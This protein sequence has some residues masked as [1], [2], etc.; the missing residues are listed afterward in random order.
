[1]IS[2]IIETNNNAEDLARTLSSLVPAAVEGVV[3]D[4]T[5]RDHGSSDAT[6]QVCDEA[7][8]RWLEVGDIGHAIKQARCDW[9]LLLM[10]GAR[11]LDGWIEPA[12]LHVQKSA[13]P[14]R[15]ARSRAHR[16]GFL[17]RIGRTQNALA[18]GLLVT[19]KQATVLARPGMNSESLARGIAAKQLSA[20]IAPAA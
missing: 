5:V 1:M 8:V 20:E 3:R 7:G 17:A 6:R 11:L 19:K 9:I 14:A 15:F 12:A 2:V 4:V 10:P 18:Q 13:A 16:L